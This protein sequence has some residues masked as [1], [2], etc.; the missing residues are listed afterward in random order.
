MPL[1][2][3]PSRFNDLVDQLISDHP[4]IFGGGSTTASKFEALCRQM[5]LR[6]QVR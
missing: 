1:F 2:P 4:A 5:S 6:N 3:G